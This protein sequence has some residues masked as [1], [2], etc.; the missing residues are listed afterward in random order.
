MIYLPPFVVH[1][2]HNMKSEDYEKKNG[3]DLAIFLEY[4]K[5]TI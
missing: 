2:T 5:I 3:F 4:M 1:G